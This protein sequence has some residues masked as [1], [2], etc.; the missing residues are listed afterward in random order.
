[1]N[2]V[3]R[4]L[5]VDDKPLALD[6]LTDYIGRIDGLELLLAT[7]DP[8]AALNRVTTD[9]V[10]LIFLDIQ[11]PQLSGLQ[12]LSALAGRAGV[13]LTTAYAEYALEGFEHDVIDYLLKPI[14]FERFYRAVQKARSRTSVDSKPEPRPYLFV[15]TEHRLHRITLDKLRYVAGMQNYAVLHTASETVVAK[16]TLSSLT[17]LLLPPAFVRVHKSYIVSVAHITTIERNRIQ[18]GGAE[19][20]VLI[21]IGDVFR[22][23]FFRLI[24][25]VP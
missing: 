5:V 21:P 12:F 4:C 14:S 25:S 17:E 22:E 11:M 2:T 7:T 24:N 23:G 6:I 8:V 16:Q 19:P 1:M 9:P 13:I 15:R 10:D 20:P 18:L 3:L